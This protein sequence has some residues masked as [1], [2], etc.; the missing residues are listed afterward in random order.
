MAE[1]GLFYGS[2]YG[3]TRKVA[4]MLRK[5]LGE[6]LVDVRNVAD[7]EAE[8]LEEYDKLIFGTS[9]YGMGSLEESWADFI[10]ELDDVDLSGKTV[11]I[12]GLGDQEEYPDSFV[13]AIAT[14]YDK[15]VEKG[16]TVVGFWPNEGYTFRKSKALKDNMFMGLVID[17]DRQRDLT[18]ERVEKWAGLLREQLL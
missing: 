3:N 15:C 13:D 18:E 9:T 7:A 10:W 12:F 11:A 6:D 14:V 2:T 1:I 8:D 17:Q 16:A 4:Q 5:A